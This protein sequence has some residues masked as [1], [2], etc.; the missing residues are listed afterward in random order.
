MSDDNSQF[1]QRFLL[2]EADVFC[3]NAWDNVDWSEEKAKEALEI[4]DKQKSSPVD[5]AHAAALLQKPSDKW[6]E[7]YATHA[8]KFFLDRNWIEREFFPYV[9]EA[10]QE[11]GTNIAFLLS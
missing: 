5:E 6:E 10:A 1:G 3:H 4:V 2:E 11:V 7:F 9:L 8:S